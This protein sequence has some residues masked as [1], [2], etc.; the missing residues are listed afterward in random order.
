[1]SSSTAPRAS[2]SLD[3]LVWGATGFTGKLVAEFLL[4]TYGVDGRLRWALGGRNREKLE[5]VRAGL[6]VI[7]PRARN[8]AIVLG[9]SA[10]RASLDAM[11]RGTR[12]VVT[13]V[14]PYAIYGAELVA[15]CVDAATDYCDLTGEPQFIRDMIDRHHARARETG[16]RIVHCCGYDSIPS[17]LGTLFA[18]DVMRER[19]GV[20]CAEVKCFAG[21]QKGGISG[22][23]VASMIHLVKTASRDARVRRVLADPYALDPDRGAPGPDGRGQ[24]GVRWDRDIGRW[25]GPFAMAAIN[26]RVVRRTNALLGYAYGRDFRYHEAMSL[27]R[28]P[29]GFFA[30]AGVS[31][32]TGA[33]FGAMAIRPVR[34]LVAKKLPAPG[35][36]PSKAVRDSGFFVTRL[37]GIAQDS[38]SSPPP[39]VFVTVNGTGD[40]GYG[41]TS[42]MLSESAVCLA[43]DGDS[44]SDEGGILTPAACM[45]SRLVERLGRAGIVFGELDGFAP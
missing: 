45:G 24:L 20:G 38:G 30:A 28:G 37:V 27:P 36:G 32:G 1:V 16:A 2:R 25:T 9:D 7:D 15:A 29:K 23:T 33:F 35:E 12:V 44:I 14:G 3:V 8:L 19:H 17:D 11:V 22:G 21:E 4:R 13:T 5:K 26:A 43:L 31:L 18:Q 41:A 40:P 39:K 10:D 42:R 34:S 6:E